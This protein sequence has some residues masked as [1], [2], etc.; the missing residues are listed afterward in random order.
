MSIQEKDL[1]NV[2]KRCI[3]CNQENIADFFS[4][5]IYTVQ[6]CNDCGA[7]FLNP[8]FFEDSINSV[9]KDDYWSN[10][11]SHISKAATTNE[12]GMS[13]RAQ[14]DIALLSKYFSKKISYLD[15]GFGMAHTLEAA[16]K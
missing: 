3:C 14:G 13:Q 9:Y 6:K 4:R 16:Q 1:V 15:I 10:E 12:L 2:L 7:Q 8:R 5:E 11:S